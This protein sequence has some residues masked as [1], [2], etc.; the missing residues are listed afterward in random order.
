[1]KHW[2]RLT[3][4]ALCLLAA[5]CAAVKGVPAACPADPAFYHVY[6]RKPSQPQ[7]PNPTYVRHVRK[8]DWDRG[9]AACQSGGGC[10]ATSNGHGSPPP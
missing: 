8:A 5:G 7:S 4:G 1:M 2:R 10:P 9:Q 6:A 3:G